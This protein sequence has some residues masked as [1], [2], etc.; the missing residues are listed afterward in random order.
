MDAAQESEAAARGPTGSVW[1]RTLPGEGRIQ[2]IFSRYAGS[3]T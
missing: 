2:K 3:A 1:M